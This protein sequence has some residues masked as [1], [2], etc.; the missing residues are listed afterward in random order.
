MKTTICQKKNKLYIESKSQMKT[1]IERS[2]E[3]QNG[4]TQF[5]TEES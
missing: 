3:L 5:E 4:I 2:V 1:A